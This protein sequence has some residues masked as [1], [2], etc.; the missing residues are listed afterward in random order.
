MRASSRTPHLLSLFVLPVQSRLS[1][2]GCGRGNSLVLGGE[3]KE[4]TWPGRFPWLCWIQKRSW[5]KTEG[6][7]SYE[8]DLSQGKGAG[9][10]RPLWGQLFSFSS[11]TPGNLYK[12][13]SEAPTS[14]LT[15]ACSQLP[16]CQGGRRNYSFSCSEV[17][18]MWEYFK[19]SNL[20]H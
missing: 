4:V 6:R 12:Q 16:Q 1:E 8:W 19:Y 13:M 3:V 11:A 2:H 17:V 5:V 7:T 20:P 15:W 14:K 18:E 10:L 9:K